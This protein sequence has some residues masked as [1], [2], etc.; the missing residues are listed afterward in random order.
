MGFFEEAYRG[1]PPWDIGRAQR[2]FVQL[3]E[4]GEI[5]GTVLDVGCGKGDNALFFADQGHEVLGVDT[6]PSAIEICRR[7]A[8]ERDLAATFLVHDTLRVHEIGRT[9]DTVT[10]S[11]FFHTLS[12]QERPVYVHTLA[13]VLEPGGRY[14]MLAFS[15]REPEGYGPR[16]ITKDEIRAAFSDGWRIDAI[17]DAVFESRTRPQGSRAW[18]SSITRT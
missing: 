18:L 16:R 1:T 7:K 14:F 15:D 12:D 3:E 10:D 11:G 6:V 9:F 2:E 5:V 17:R 4:S 13:R 8:D